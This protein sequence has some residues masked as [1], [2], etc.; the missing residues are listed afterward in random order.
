MV[1]AVNLKT[2]K[3]LRFTVLGW[4]LIQAHGF[5]QGK[6]SPFR[7]EPVDLNEFFS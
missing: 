6:G 1:E 5:F 4:H 3:R 7:I 2:G